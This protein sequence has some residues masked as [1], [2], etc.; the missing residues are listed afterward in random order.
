MKRDK[1]DNI[2]VENGV[3]KLV[4]RDSL[5]YCQERGLSFIH[6]WLCYLDMIDRTNNETINSIIHDE[7][8][9]Q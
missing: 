9:E 1:V 6:W 5:L 7:S 2:V 8:S 4:A 3:L